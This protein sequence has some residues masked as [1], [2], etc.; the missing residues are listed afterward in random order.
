MG[1]ASNLKSVAVAA[2]E[3][4]ISIYDREDPT[5]LLPLIA[6][7]FVRQTNQRTV[8]IEWWAAFPE[9]RH[10]IGDRQTQEAFSELIQVRVEPYEVTYALDRLD[11]ELDGDR[12]LISSADELAEAIAKAF[13]LGRVD[14]A[15]Q[16]LRANVTAYDG[17]DF[18]DTDHTHPNGDTYANYAALATARAATGAPTALEAA[19]ELKQAIAGL[20]DNSVIQSGLTED[21]IAGDMVVVA[22]SFGVWKGYEDLRTEER[23]SDG[24][25]NRFR[26][27]FRLLRDRK[28]VSGT[29]KMVDY[30]SSPPGGPRPSVFVPAK[31]PRGIEYDDKD[32]F[33]A[34]KIEFGSDANYGFGAGFPQMAYRLHE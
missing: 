24:T 2:T 21:N 10:W 30:I 33:S 9:I 13:R 22:K 26:N 32:V 18:F 34:R 16:P 7:T 5:D 23:F 8:N 27:T 15:Y 4:M 3:V 6:R 28:P 31:E 20:A 12:S 1:L 25:I 11:L 14:K 17:Q 29:E 19:G